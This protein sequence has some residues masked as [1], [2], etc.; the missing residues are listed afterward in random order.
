MHRETPANASVCASLACAAL[1]SLGCSNGVRA[2][3]SLGSGSDVAGSGSSTGVPAPSGNGTGTGANS[4]VGSTGGGADAASGMVGGGASG[5]AMSGAGA[6]GIAV[7]GSGIAVSASG[8]PAAVHTS[9]SVLERNKH[10]SRDGC[11]TEKTLTKASLKTIALDAAFNAT[12]TGQM[13]ASPLYLDKG[14]AGKG[15]FIAATTSN[16]EFALHATHD[17]APA[18]QHDR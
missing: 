9:L 1:V 13:Y 7:S 2:D 8:T 5:I 12:F 18:K 11:F 16:N 10:P 17:H 6:S 4:S 14:P 15:S 3:T